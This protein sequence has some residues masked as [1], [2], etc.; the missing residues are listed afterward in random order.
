MSL[1]EMFPKLTF[2]VVRG[3]WNKKFQPK[4]KINIQN[5]IFCTLEGSLGIKSIS[6]FLHKGDKT[7]LSIEFWRR[8]LHNKL[9]WE[10]NNPGIA[11]AETGKI[12]RKKD[13]DE[14]RQDYLIALLSGLKQ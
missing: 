12:Y 9:D 2:F 10:L 1:I 7:L 5:R 3:Q 11:F 8:T 4:A 6:P 14:F 13:L